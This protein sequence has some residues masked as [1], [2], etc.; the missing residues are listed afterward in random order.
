MQTNTVFPAGQSTLRFPCKTT[1]APGAPF[2]PRRPRGP[3]NSE[4]DKPLRLF[5]NIFT[6]SPSALW[7]KSQ[8]EDPALLRYFTDAK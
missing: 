4:Y 6:T 3:R 5:Q 7:V 8:T 2:R 1:H